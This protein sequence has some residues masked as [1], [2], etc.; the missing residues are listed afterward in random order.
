MVTYAN[1]FT[2]N[3]FFVTN[4]TVGGDALLANAMLMRVLGVVLTAVKARYAFRLVGH[5]FLPDQMQLILEP[6]PGVVVDQVMT[7]VQKGFQADYHQLNGMPGAMLLWEKMY[8]TQRVKDETDFANRLDEIHYGPV[9][10]GWV[11]KPEAWPYSSYRT[12][13]A[14]GL[15]PE[16]W[17]WTP[18]VNLALPLAGKGTRER[19]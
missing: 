2:P 8:R 1:L 14:Q 15:Y 12:W 10:H 7:A 5:L 16:G 11:D 18:P 17:G 6:A 19:R 13:L 9:Q 4:R 3:L